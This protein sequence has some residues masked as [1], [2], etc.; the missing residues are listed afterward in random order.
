MLE[1]WVVVLVLL[2]V[3]VAVR[4]KPLQEP[5]LLPLQSLELQVQLLQL[6]SLL[7]RSSPLELPS[8][9][10]TSIP[11]LP[12]PIRPICF[13][14]PAVPNSDVAVSN[15]VGGFPPHRPSHPHSPTSPR[16]CFSLVHFP[17]PNCHN[18]FGPPFPRRTSTSSKA[19]WRWTIVPWY[20]IPKKYVTPMRSRY[21]LIRKA[22]YSANDLSEPNRVRTVAGFST[23]P[24]AFRAVSQKT[25]NSGKPST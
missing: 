7:P 2:L 3:L 9:G 10:S 15:S 11:R 8:P 24:R 1:S 5:S 4:P 19:S 12:S 22:K 21:G 14:I 23:K 25:K 17:S 13:C 6:P 18:R 20:E 16:I